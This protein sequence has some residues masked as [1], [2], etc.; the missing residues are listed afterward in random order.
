VEGAGQVVVQ[1]EG[2]F[3]YDEVQ[4]RNGSTR[5]RVDY[6]CEVTTVADGCL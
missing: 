2:R 5:I 1:V 4:F 6:R 3:Q